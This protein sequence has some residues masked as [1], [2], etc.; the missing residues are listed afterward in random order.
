MKQTTGSRAVS[1]QHK[2]PATTTRVRARERE[3]QVFCVSDC[4]GHS[5]GRRRWKVDRERLECLFPARTT[6]PGGGPAVVLQVADG[7]VQDLEDGLLGRELPAVAGGLAEPGVHRLDQVGRV[8]DPA[9]LLGER[10]ERH[11]L[12][13]P[14]PPEPDDRRIPGPP[15][16]VEGVEGGRGG[17]LVDS[18]GDRA[19]ALG[20]RCPVLLRAYRSEAR[21][22][23]TTQSCTVAWGQT[24]VTASGSP[25]RPSQ[26][27]MHTSP[28][29]R[30]R[31][32]ARTVGQN[33]A[34]SPVVGPT[35]IRQDLLHP[36]GVDPDREIHRTV[37][38]DPV[39]DLH[40]QRVDEDH[41]I[42]R[43]GPTDGPATAGVPRRRRQ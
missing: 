20:E 22:R 39:P 2:H 4:G 38:D 26:Q 43:A 24:T 33:F 15:A 16:G 1:K 6:D 34:D 32:S 42:D 19:Q 29:P 13:P 17:G 12:L 11:E 41:R 21:I 18:G 35:R 31:S 36:V 27:T 28:R 9:D 30:L 23:W 8:D 37:R 40:H 25:V 5:V 10:E 14:D 3:R 7:E